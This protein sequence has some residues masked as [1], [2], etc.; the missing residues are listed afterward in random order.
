MKEQLF[1]Q[2]ENDWVKFGYTKEFL[3][4]MRRQ[5][6]WDAQYGKVSEYNR[7]IARGTVSGL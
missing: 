6:F 1:A 7:K 2:K 5:D 4:S 3:D